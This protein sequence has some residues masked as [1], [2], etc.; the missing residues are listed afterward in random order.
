[1]I[2]PAVRLAVALPLLLL[3]LGGLL[4]AAKRGLIRLPGATLGTAPLR[5]V[6]VATL[7][8][9]ARLA[10]VEFDGERLLLGVARDGITRLVRQ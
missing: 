1:V 3:L 9:G 6:Q 4:L 7:G 8:P 5:I 2:E 10:V